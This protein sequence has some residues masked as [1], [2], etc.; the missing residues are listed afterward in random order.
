MVRPAPLH[1]A[2]VASFVSLASIGAVAA[3]AAVAGCARTSAS[4]DAGTE[5]AASLSPVAPSGAP[6]A[7]SSASVLSDSSA[8]APAPG[9]ES[10]RAELVKLDA[11]PELASQSELVK[12]HFGAAPGPFLV[13]RLTLG[14]GRRMVLVSSRD[15]SDPLLVTLDGPTLLWAKERPTAGMTPPAVNL[16]ITTHPSGGAVLFA[17]D[18]PTKSVAARVWEGD[19]APF[20]D[21]QV[22]KVDACDDLSAAR[23]PGRGWVVA[24]AWLGGARAQLLREDGTISWRRD[25]VD[26]GAPWRAPAPLTI[27]LDAESALVL[28]QR[29]DVRPGPPGDHVVVTRYDA[30]GRP[31]WAAPV[32]LGA[33]PAVAS[34]RSRVAARQVGGSARVEVGRGRFV[35]VDPSGTKSARPKHGFEP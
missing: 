1:F 21:F 8:P 29:A 6:F 22:M 19:G 31:A 35:D 18:A 3:V 32:D 17:Y 5:A 24:C 14:G 2:L 23:W 30:R 15:E 25:G 27:V 33:V 10:E 11:D 28:V 9:G 16:A 20:A 13:Q 7:A 34:T 4:A 26:V 12:K